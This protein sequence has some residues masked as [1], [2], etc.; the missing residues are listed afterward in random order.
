MLELKMKKGI[1]NLLGEVINPGL[2]TVCGACAGICPYVRV[3]REKI[4]IIDNCNLL[5]GQ[6][7]EICPR[8]R[9]DYEELNKRVFGK[10]RDDNLLGTH[11]KLVFGRAGDA[12]VRKAGQY[13]GTV[14][15]LMQY[16]LA[17]K[18]ADAALLAGRNKKFPLLPEPLVVRNADDVLDAAGS[19]YTACPT[20]SMLDKTLK[21]FH[22]VSV[23][24]R[25][26]QV[27][28][29]RKKQVFDPEAKRVGPIIGLFCMWALDYM[30]LET[31]LAEKI[32]I[33]KVRK[34][35]IPEGDFVVYTQ[36]G[37]QRFSFEEIKNRRRATCDL[38]YDFTNE[39]ADISVGATELENDWNTVIIRSDVGEKL[40]RDALG[41]DI[42]EEKPFPENRIEL[43]RNAALGKKRRV[44]AAL[45]E[46]FGGT[47]EK[48]GYLVLSE[49]EAG[50]YK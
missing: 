26:C 29:L 33:A 47:E 14:S 40:W 38:C 36:D 11:S 6:C 34:Y 16:I 1:L 45:S 30:Q 50:G 15:A 13:G 46:K 49:K 17:S 35:D 21:E 32:D 23:V 44:I 19:K 37:T 7:Y 22:R 41:A 25:G 27:A 42:V 48:L 12:A 8:T 39:F 4:S 24:G 9:T 3:Y 10:S 43:F 5:E 2:C 31:F 18:K 28:A 20:L